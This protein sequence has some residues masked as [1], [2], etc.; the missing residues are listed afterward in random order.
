M[1]W[2]YNILPKK[3]VMTKED[4][5]DFENSTKWWICNSLCPDG[6]VQVRYYCHFTEKYIGSSE[7]DSNT[8]VKL[9]S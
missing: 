2:W 5:E 6:D 7:R 1:I 8:N 9:K 3:I 4:A